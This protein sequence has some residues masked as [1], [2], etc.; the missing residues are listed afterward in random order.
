MT[1]HYLQRECLPVLACVQCIDTPPA[2]VRGV[3]VHR[4]SM[5]VLALLRSF[6]SVDCEVAQRGLFGLSGDFGHVAVVVAAPKSQSGGLTR[7][8]RRGQR[9][10]RQVV[11]VR[12]MKQADEAKRDGYVGQ[13][14]RRK[15]A[16]AVTE[17]EKRTGKRAQEIKKIGGLTHRWHA[18]RMRSE[19]NNTRQ[20]MKRWDSQAGNGVLEGVRCVQCLGA[21]GPLLFALLRCRRAR[22][23][24][25]LGVPAH[26]RTPKTL[27]Q[28]LHIHL[29]HHQERKKERQRVRCS[30]W[31]DGCVRRTAH[32][33]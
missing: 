5:L 23:R 22:F 17:R 25:R 26:Q 14:V 12:Q 16:F 13:Y 28:R 32:V 6:G 4:Y 31:R 33:N 15:R 3:C 9:L 29:S 27:F 30:E 18:Q 7:V 20:A 21:R 8:S 11:F 2:R 24:L 19:T 1:C 10:Q